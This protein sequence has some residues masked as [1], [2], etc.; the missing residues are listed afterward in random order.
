MWGAAP[1]HRGG[2]LPVP[3]LGPH[4]ECVPRP[5][6]FVQILFRSLLE[7]RRGG[8]SKGIFRQR[9]KRGGT[10][11]CTGM[12]SDR[13]TRCH[14][15]HVTSTHPGSLASPP[16]ASSPPTLLLSSST[17]S[18]STGGRRRRAG[19]LL[20]VSLTML[21]VQGPHSEHVHHP[22]SPSSSTRRRRTTALAPGGEEE[23]DLP[24]RCC[25]LSSNSLGGHAPLSLSVG[26]SLLLVTSRVS[27]LRHVT[28][29]SLNGRRPCRP[30]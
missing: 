28:G 17:S 1:C 24:S 10:G 30:G 13:A 3:L 19:S 18:S 16:P 14:V 25:S 5:T 20:L 26:F 23:R 11:P 29:F 4:E 6:A 27:R 8:R 12:P 7:S 21:H 2:N 9:G 15:A 22:L